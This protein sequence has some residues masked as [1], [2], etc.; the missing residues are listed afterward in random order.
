MATLRIGITKGYKRTVQHIGLKQ[1]L[2]YAIY[3]NENNVCKSQGY[4]MCWNILH[5]IRKQT[6]KQKQNKSYNTH[7]ITKEQQ[8]EQTIFLSKKINI[9]HANLRL[10]ISCI[11]LCNIV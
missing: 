7:K 3:F 5:K 8:R 9:K 4:N 10:F 6:Y 11:N 2:N 1:K